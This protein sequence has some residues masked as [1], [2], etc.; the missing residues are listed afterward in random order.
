MGITVDEVDDFL[1]LHHAIERNASIAK[2]NKRFDSEDAPG[3]GRLKSG[4]VLTDSFVKDRM[5]NIYGM[6]WNDAS[7][8]WSG[9]NDR[10][11]AMQ[12]IAADTDQIIK[13]A[14]QKLVD[15]GLVS[16]EDAEKVV[17]FYKY[18]AP[19]R[20]KSMENDVASVIMGAG[21]LS[22][23]GGEYMRAK[24]RES[25]AESPLGHIMIMAERAISRGNK[26]TE[27]GQRLVNL[28]KDHPNSEFWDVYSPD[29]P[30]YREG[31]DR[32]YT[33][34]GADSALQG[35]TAKNISD[36]PDK[37]NWVQKVSPNKNLGVAQDRELLVV[38]D[39]GKPLYVDIKGDPRLRNA[40][41]SLD[42]DSASKIIQHLGIVNR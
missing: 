36:K 17:G 31:F 8:T 10:G 23:R 37:H 18:Y 3:A 13:E 40:M 9:G 32:N 34:I 24:G 35:Q 25:A 7:G 12:S 19:L 4:E 42:A 38:K 33:Y 27:F 39:K 16:K 22:M 29:N 20:G 28:I 11:K 30:R 14:N 1:V 26:N 5:K 2:R 21:G 15:S 41:L 6:D